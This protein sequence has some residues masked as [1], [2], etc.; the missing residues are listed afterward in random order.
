MIRGGR[1]VNTARPF[2][3][4]PHLDTMGQTAARAGAISLAESLLE[5]QGRASMTLRDLV[6]AGAADPTDAS[7]G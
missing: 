7:G 3:T 6:D 1:A 5:L 4:K 2:M